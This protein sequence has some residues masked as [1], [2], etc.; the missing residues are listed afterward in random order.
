M[1][2]LCEDELLHIFSF[3]PTKSI[4]RLQF[5]YKSLHDEIH[6]ARFR[7]NHA[8]NMSLKDDTYIFIQPRIF[9]N[10][11]D[12][13]ELF[14][15]LPPPL[16][17]PPTGKESNLHEQLPKNSLQ[18]LKK[19]KI[20]ASSNG[21][22]L[23]QSNSNKEL[24]LCNP[25]TQTWLPIT[26]PSTLPESPFHEAN[27]FFKCMNNKGLDYLDDYLIILIEGAPEWGNM[28]LLNYIRQKKVYG[29]KWRMIFLLVQ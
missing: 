1:A 2:S 23:C 15:L 7:M 27:I 4:C 28:L 22:I 16:P 9:F 12:K 21:L 3:P 14:H 25:I 19:V 20:L 18:F 5:L 29:E 8:Q 17:S 13:N 10:N 6:G 24:C 26:T 11:F